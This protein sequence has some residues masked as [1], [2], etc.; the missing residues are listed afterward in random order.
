M[1]FVK[2][3][4]N[5]IIKEMINLTNYQHLKWDKVFFD[6]GDIDFH[7]SEIEIFFYVE[8]YGTRYRFYYD[9]ESETGGLYRIKLSKV[10]KEV[11]YIEMCAIPSQ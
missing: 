10:S 9:Y 7:D 6:H 8:T 1:N 4:E 2:E 3:I 5:K 11:E